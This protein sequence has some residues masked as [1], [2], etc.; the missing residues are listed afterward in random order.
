MRTKITHGYIFTSAISK[1]STYVYYFCK[2]HTAIKHVTEVCSNILL[3]L[4]SKGIL[5]WSN[6]L[7]QEDKLRNPPTNAVANH[8]KYKL[9]LALIDRHLEVKLVLHVQRGPEG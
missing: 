9:D 4:T 1:P 8:K 2:Q 5:I 3:N 6:I 7:L